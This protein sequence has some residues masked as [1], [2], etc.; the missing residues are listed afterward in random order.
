MKVEPLSDAQPLKAQSCQTLLRS[1]SS[2]RRFVPLASLDASRRRSAKRIASALT[3]LCGCPCQTIFCKVVMLPSVSARLLAAV[4]KGVTKVANTCR[5]IFKLLRVAE[6]TTEFQVIPLSGSCP[7]H[8]YPCSWRE[9][10]RR[11]RGSAASAG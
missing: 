3:V 6:V 2:Q 7:P 5:L 8:L 1:S 9:R 10:A 11:G 4:P